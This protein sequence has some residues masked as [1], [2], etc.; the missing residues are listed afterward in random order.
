WQDSD[1]EWQEGLDFFV[2][3]GF[4]DDEEAFQPTGFSIRVNPLIMDGLQGLQMIAAVGLDEDG[5]FSDSGPDGQFAGNNIN[6]LRLAQI[7]SNKAL[8]LTLAEG[9]NDDYIS[10]TWL[11]DEYGLIFLGNTF[12]EKFH[13]FLLELGIRADSNIRL[14]ETSAY[15]TKQLEQRRS[16]ISDVSLDEEMTSMI[17]FQQAYAAAARLSAALN[18]VLTILMDRVF[19]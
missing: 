6:A 16:S 12:E 19:R 1:G 17:R 18:D 10:G 3:N 8:L 11:E 14:Y 4:E 15:Q 13:T 9:I 5:E 2:P 7:R